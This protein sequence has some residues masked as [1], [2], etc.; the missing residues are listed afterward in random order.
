MIESYNIAVKSYTDKLDKILDKLRG[1]IEKQ[2][3]EGMEKGKR[4]TVKSMMQG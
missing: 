4:Q 3:R 1:M 2:E